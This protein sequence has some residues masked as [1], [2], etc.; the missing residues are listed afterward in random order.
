MAFFTTEDG[1]AKACFASESAAMGC[2]NGQI[3][4][5]TVTGIQT[6]IHFCPDGLQN[7][8]PYSCDMY[9]SGEYRFGRAIAQML[10]TPPAPLNP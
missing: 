4:I 2:S 3:A 7:G 6:G 5:R 9:S 1:A 8:Y 10:V